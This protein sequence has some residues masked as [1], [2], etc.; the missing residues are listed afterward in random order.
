L[1][2]RKANPISGS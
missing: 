1:L 2:W